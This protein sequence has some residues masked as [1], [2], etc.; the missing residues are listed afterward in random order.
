M[1]KL[2]SLLVLL[3]FFVSEAAT[4]SDGAMY[5]MNQLKISRP[6]P[7]QFV[8]FEK[9]F[10]M[11]V[12]GGSGELLGT[13]TQVIV[14]FVSAGGMQTAYASIG[15]E[16]SIKL[17]QSILR[18][19]GICAMVAIYPYTQGEPLVRSAF[20]SIVLFSPA[21]L[22]TPR[23]YIPPYNP[24][25]N[26]CYNPYRPICTIPRPRRESCNIPRPRCHIRQSENSESVD[27]Q[28]Y[29]DPG[30]SLF[31]D[32]QAQAIEQFQREYEQ[33]LIE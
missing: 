21:P 3:G 1:F 24:C 32:Q 27:F 10:D 15:V 29:Y 14:M 28:M 31:V 20:S 26:P 5:A 16:T 18:S 9:D 13:G 25:Y 17:H 30:L 8:E 6:S 4:T 12:E 19:L 22:P 23:P 11:L 2:A 7:G 33:H